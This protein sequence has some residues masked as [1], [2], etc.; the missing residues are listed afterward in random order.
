M[1]T[2]NN[3]QETIKGQVK[4]MIL[5][6]IA[7]IFSLVLISLTVT[8][9][10]FWNQF[11]TTSTSGKIAEL[12]I[13]QPSE[14]EKANAANDAIDAELAAKANN[15]SE[16]FICE[17]EIEEEPEVE[18]WMIDNLNFSNLPSI[19]ATESESAPEIEDWMTDETYFI[20]KASLLTEDAEE[21]LNLKDWMFS[22]VH[23]N[24]QNTLLAVD[25]EPVP[26]VEDWMT[27]E[28]FFLTVEALTAQEAEMEIRKY[29]EKLILLQEKRTAEQN[30]ETKISNLTSIFAVESEPA[31]E[32]EFWMTDENFF[33]SA[34]TLTARSAVQEIN[35]YAQKQIAHQSY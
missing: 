16:T 30:V 17:P 3:A 23:F 28:D 18:A 35:K 6:G 31:L 8:A 27:N 5:R 2:K 7:V 26:E 34:E 25:A 20:A 29:A 13:E 1:K 12:K 11:L 32:I 22:N 24:N 4:S 21:A 10:N 15:S 33:K 9:Q 19:L 14:F